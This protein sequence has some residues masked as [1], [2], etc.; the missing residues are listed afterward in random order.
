MW[1]LLDADQG[2]PWPDQPLVY[3]QKYRF[4]Y[5][6]YDPLV[7]VITLPRAVWAIGAFIG[8]QPEDSNTECSDTEGSSTWHATVL[9]LLTTYFLLYPQVSMTSRSASQG[10]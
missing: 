4:Y 7:H 10:L 8:T 2:Q 5:Q 9:L 3:Y 1:S 6:E